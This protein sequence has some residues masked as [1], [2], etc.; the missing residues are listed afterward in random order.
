MKYRV[1]YI[2]PPW[3]YSTSL[4]GFGKR[5]GDVWKRPGSITPYSTMPVQDIIDLRI[6]DLMH[7]DSH[8]YLWST[9]T[10]LPYA[11]ECI[12]AWGFKYSTPLF[13]IKRPRGFQG[14]PTFNNCVEILFFARRGSWPSMA[15][16][17]RNWWI[18]PRR[19]HSSKPQFFADLIEKA[20]PG[21]RVELFA[22]EHRIGWRGM[23]WELTG[24]DIRD[25]LAHERLRIAA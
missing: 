21:N 16:F 23:G 2:D 24:T 8:L 18:L 13:W 11:L 3:P 10:H 9:I 7:D 22:R 1:G 12:K 25:D 19:R 17:D 15:R 5:E 6:A 4:P 14:F 20:S